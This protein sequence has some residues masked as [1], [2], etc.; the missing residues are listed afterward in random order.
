MIYAQTS[1]N[2][3]VCADGLRYVMTCAGGRYLVI[4]CE[5]LWLVVLDGDALPPLR[6][7]MTTGP[8]DD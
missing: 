2:S 1:R 8:S 4:H 7:S 6:G 5:I 3:T